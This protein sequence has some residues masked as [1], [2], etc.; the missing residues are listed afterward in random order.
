MRKENT[1]H[2]AGRAWDVT[3]ITRDGVRCAFCHEYFSRGSE[4]LA[5]EGEHFCSEECFEENEKLGAELSYD[6][7]YDPMEVNDW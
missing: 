3:T 1:M 2:L 4:A 6:Q 5:S 7:R